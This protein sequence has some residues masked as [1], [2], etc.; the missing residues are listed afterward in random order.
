MSRFIKPHFVRSVILLIVD[1]LCVLS[2]LFSMLK[3]T[4]WGNVV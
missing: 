1:C 2:V 3:P 4:D